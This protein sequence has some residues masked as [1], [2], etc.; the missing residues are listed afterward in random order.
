MTPRPEHPRPDFQRETWQNLNGEWEFTLDPADRGL[1]ENWAGRDALTDRIM[2]PYPVESELS[3]VHNPRPP[4]VCWYLKKFDLGPALEFSPGKGRLLLHFGAVD[5]HA[6]V[7]LNGVKLGEHVGGYSPFQFDVT[8]LAR[9]SGNTLVVRVFDSKDRM[10]VRGKQS[11]KDK[12]YG[13]WY[14]T[15]T[16]IWQTVWLERVGDPYL[17]SFKFTAAPDLSGGKF[18]LELSRDAPGVTPEIWVTRPE[19]RGLAE[20]NLLLSKNLVWK[21]PKTRAWSP[22]DPVLY[23]VSIELKDPDGNKL[24]IVSSYVGVRTIEA[25]NGKIH[26]NGKPFYQKLL[27]DQGFFPGGVYTPRD[28]E[29]M[30]ADCEIYKRMGFNGL[31]KHQKIEDPRFLYWCDRLG[32]VVWEEM[33]SL[34][35]GILGRVP[36][37]AVDRFRDEWL[38]VIARDLNHPCIITWTVFNEN[39]GIYEML[40][41][42]AS[43]RF[44]YAMVK[45]TREADPSRLVVD[46]SG[47]WHFDTDVWDFHHYLPTVQD[48]VRLYERYQLKPGDHISL[49]RYFLNALKGELVIPNFLPGVDYQ[50]QPVLLSEYGGFGFYR[51]EGDESLLEKYRSYTLAVSRFPNIVGYCYTQP[52]DVEQEQNGLMTFDRVPKIEPEKIKEVNDMVGGGN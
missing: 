49:G 12:S 42:K 39:W 27:L 20:S 24:D 33:P 29:A 5:Y 51:T 26:L 1:R 50:G 41:S 4:E 38:D 40:W 32:L 18:T 8:E 46:N 10:Q 13:I 14:T 48:S 9:P 52:Y 28:D 31:R 19:E 47:G 6:M 16:G 25:R 22:D 37:Q 11:T 2:V 44:G 34:G 35:F 3:G 21:E 30:R 45:A 23:G 36:D 17:K 15:T 43:R 7:W